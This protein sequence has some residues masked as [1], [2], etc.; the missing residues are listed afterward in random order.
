MN[1]RDGLTPAEEVTRERMRQLAKW[2][3]Q[4]HDPLYGLAIFVEEVGEVGKA[5]CE[6]DWAGYRTE[7]IH[8]AA[9]AISAIA[10]FDRNGAPQ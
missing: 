7:L 1:K 3:E 4:N 8:A 10:S 6:R 5:A 9:V 2:G